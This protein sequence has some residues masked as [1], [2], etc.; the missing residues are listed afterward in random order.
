MDI[1][2]GSQGDT[3]SLSVQ[4]Y[5]VHLLYCAKLLS[6][7]TCHGKGETEE[8][9]KE[10]VKENPPKQ[11]KASKPEPEKLKPEV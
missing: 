8:E 10:K 4:R 6:Y 2:K 7:A 3:G 1:L 11:D 5:P 9:K